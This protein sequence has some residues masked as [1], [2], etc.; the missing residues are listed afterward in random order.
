LKSLLD[1]VFGKNNFRNEITWCYRR[2]SAESNRFQR[3]HDIILF[4]GKSDVNT[5]NRLSI[6][7]T[8]GQK[9]KHQRGYD[10]NS[11]LIDGKRQPQ[12]IVYEQQKV[13]EAV[14]AGKLDT[15]DF[16]RTVL[17]EKTG[18]TMPD[19]WEMPIINSQSKERTGYPTREYFQPF[20]H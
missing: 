18:T 19:V 14:K 10:R 13:D 17:V 6:E 9:I 3:M 12:L 2:W 11:V 1:A 20:I 16:V 5:F 8:K 7:P 15:D 4:Y